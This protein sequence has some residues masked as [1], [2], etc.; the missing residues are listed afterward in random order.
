VLRELPPEGHGMK[1]LVITDEWD[2]KSAGGCSNF[3]MFDKN[4]AFAIN[5]LDD[6]EMQIRLNILAE[7]SP[8]GSSLVTSPD[9]FQY[10]VNATV[11]RV[12]QPKF[13]PLPGSLDLK[14]LTNPAITTNNGKFSNNLSSMVSERVTISIYITFYRKNYRREYM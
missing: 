3:G 13:P 6:C 5:V 11:F 4:P 9:K 2:F 10:C 7:L 12:P 1:K 14:T 8:E